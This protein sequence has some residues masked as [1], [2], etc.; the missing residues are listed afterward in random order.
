MTALIVIGGFAGSG[1]SELSAGLA[2]DLAMP[3]LNS[4]VIGGAIRESLHDADAFRAGYDV[5]FRLAD[6][7][8]CSGCST[9]IDTNMGWDFQWRR[10]DDIVKRRPG[11]VFLPMILRCPRELCM[12]RIAKRDV[13]GSVWHRP[14][15]LDRVW[16]FLDRLDRPDIRWLDATAPAESVRI[17]ALRHVTHLID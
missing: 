5:L 10:I 1:K 13:D 14:S 4:D 16:A 2:R 6:E 9:I 8:L 17:E 15:H 12:D 7:F 3:R 11:L